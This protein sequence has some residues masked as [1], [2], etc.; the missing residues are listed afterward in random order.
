MVR[1][2]LKKRFTKANV[3]LEVLEKAVDT[4]TEL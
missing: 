1:T 2:F 3:S 4:F